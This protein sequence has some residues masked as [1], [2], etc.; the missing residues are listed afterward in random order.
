MYCRKDRCLVGEKEEAEANMGVACKELFLGTLALHQQ[1]SH[2]Y[3]LYPV[4]HWCFKSQISAFMAG[5]RH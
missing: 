3:T 5:S 1:I 2:I 4:A